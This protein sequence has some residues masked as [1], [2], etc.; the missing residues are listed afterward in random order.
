MNEFIFVLQT[1]M[2][3]KIIHVMINMGFVQI[4]Q[5]VSVVHARRDITAMGPKMGKVA[6]LRTLHFQ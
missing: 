3:V 1:S 4:H 5:G 2:N 6:L